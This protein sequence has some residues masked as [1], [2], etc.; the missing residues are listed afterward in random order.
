M[1]LSHLLRRTALG[2]LALLALLV[3]TAPAALAAESVLGPEGELLRVL[4]GTYGELFPEG[5]AVR[6][7][8]VV[9]ALEIIRGDSS[10]RLLVPG[11]ASRGVERSASLVYEAGSDTLYIAWSSLTERVNAEINLVGRR[12]QDWGDVIEVSGNPY[13]FKSTPHLAVT[14]D[15]LP[16]EGDQPARQRTIL[17][18]VWQ[19]EDAGALYAPLVLI[20]GEFQSPNRVHSLSAMVPDSVE[21]PEVGFATIEPIVVPGPDHNSVAIAFTHTLSGELV[22]LTVSPLP[23][24]LTE[25]ADGAEDFVRTTNLDPCSSDQAAAL[26]RLLGDEVLALGEPLQDSLRH[27]LAARA[28]SLISTASA[29]ACAEDLDDVRI[30]VAEAARAHIILIGARELRPGPVDQI[31]KARA[32]IILI[33]LVS[34]PVSDG[35]S[36]GQGSVSRVSRFAAT[37]Q[38]RSP[39]R[40]FLSSDG[41]RV[42]AAW[43]GEQ[44]RIRYREAIDEEGWSDSRELIL[45]E[46]LGPLEAWDALERRVQG[47]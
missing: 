37:T 32:H 45:G 39:D 8:N 15:A 19:E 36:D 46:D 38:D 25:V 28:E 41:R 30:S 11:T 10:E 22:T 21:A 34:G 9:L 47:R 26:G 4:V 12:G 1:N 6:E 31:R 7:S 35:S 13:S 24:E 16:A 23:G 5:E 33:G 18:T 2:A 43:I 3:A 27:Y 29:G 20:D 14:R 40:L 42:I 44:N 17:H